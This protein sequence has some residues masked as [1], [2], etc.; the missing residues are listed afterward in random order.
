MNYKRTIT[1]IAFHIKGK[2]R[3]HC[4]ISYD[5][6][7]DILSIQGGYGLSSHLQ[8]D[9]G[10]YLLSPFRERDL[11]RL[12]AIVLKYSGI[13][14]G[15]QKQ[16]R[17]VR[18]I[19]KDGGLYTLHDVR[20]KLNELGLLCDGE[21]VYGANWVY[22]KVPDY[23]LKWLFSLPGTGASYE[24]IFPAEISNEDLEAILMCR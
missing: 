21:N 5:D 23:I 2:R 17:A 19:R 16:E 9:R 13:K 7:K 6:E 15:T 10:G 8:E 12:N 11:A 18:K 24:D 14:N 1:P 20:R 4:A 3:V 22:P